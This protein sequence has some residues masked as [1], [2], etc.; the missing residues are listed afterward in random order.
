[1]GTFSLL[2]GN[3]DEP[4][5][6]KHREQ[7]NRDQRLMV[8]TL[9]KA[10]HTQKWVSTHLGFTLRQV[11]YVLTVPV[12]P[13]KRTG[14]PPVLT[15]EQVQGLILFI[16]T[17]KETRQMM[18]LE[19]ARHFEDMCLHHTVSREQRILSWSTE[20]SQVATRTWSTKGSTTTIYRSGCNKPVT[21]PTTRASFGTTTRSTTTTNLSRA[22]VMAQAL[23]LTLI[24]TNTTTH[25]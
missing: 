13:Q 7:L 11:Q 22:A 9:Y 8:H 25:I 20:S 18:H 3:M 10:G 2:T 14:R 17:S 5:T 23:F 21:I 19:L 12:T 6:P 1:M 15:L 16:R 4:S 24:R